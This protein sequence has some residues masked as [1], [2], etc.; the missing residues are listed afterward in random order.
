MIVGDP[1]QFAIES[2]ISHA[3][4]KPSILAIGF[5]NIH[6]SGYR[7]GLNKSDSTAFGCTFDDVERRLAH[8][9]SHVAPFSG[10]VD[11]GRI[12][13][14]VRNALYA[15]E[16]RESYFGLP[17]AE[18]SKLIHRNHLM[19]APSGD[20]AFDDDSYVLQ[21]DLGDQARLIGFKS[22]ADFTYESSTLRDVRIRQD[23]F[24]DI[25]EQWLLLFEKERTS[26]L[27]SQGWQEEDYV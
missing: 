13:E 2:G 25:L 18:F 15:D 19:W 23:L 11:P 27:E 6:I 20:E 22:H 3:S 1:A 9:G 21:F 10:E 12:A 16:G 7:Y 17:I 5:F 4:K 24:Y 26:L 8:R 14:S